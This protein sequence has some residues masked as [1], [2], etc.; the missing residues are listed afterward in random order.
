[1]HRILV[2]NPGSTSTKIAVYADSRVEIEQ[3]LHHSHEELAPYERIIDQFEFRKNLVVQCLQEQ[4][5]PLSSLDAVVGRGGLVYPLE[6]GCYRVNSLMR[7]D[8]RNAIMG[9]HASNLGALIANAIGDEIGQPS[10]IVDPVVVDELEPLARYSGSPEVSRLSIFHALNQKEAAR[11]MAES[12]NKSYH[13]CNMIVAHLG[14]GISI[15]AH[16]R[17]KVIDV[18]NALD[19]DGPFSP[20]RTG[21]LPSGQLARLCFLGQWSLDDIKKL[22]KGHGG[23]VAYLGTNDGGEIMKRIEAGDD[24]AR[25]VFEAMAY[26]V[27][28]EIGAMTTVLKGKVDAIVLTGGLAH[29]DRFVNW[30]IERVQFIA[31]VSVMPGEDEMRAMY[32]SALRVIT[33]KETAKEYLGKRE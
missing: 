13:E 3:K 4:K 26:Q 11:R 8:L 15:G 17:G 18:N 12:L 29:I 1:M 24:K 23:M 28:K 22:I 21:G 6:G 19:G 16:R 27:A 10:F 9:E 33:G 14:G 20:E 2:I 7:Q 30:I 25:E 32:E 31:P 5:I